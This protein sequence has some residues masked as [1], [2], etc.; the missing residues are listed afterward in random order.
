MRIGAAAAL[1]LI[2]LS[3]CGR[4]GPEPKPTAT[5]STEE[6]I[7]RATLTLLASDD[8]TVCVEP[9]TFGSPLSMWRIATQGKLQ[10]SYDLAWSPP[11]PFRPPT[12]P[13][14]RDL[15]SSVQAGKHANLAEPQMR[16]DLLPVSMQASLQ[17]QA[18]ALAPPDVATHRVTISPSWVPAGVVL[19]WW[20]EGSKQSGCDAQYVL[21]GIKW[22]GHVAFIGVRVEHW[23][24]VFALAPH[25]D[26][27]RPIAQ[28]G[29][30]LY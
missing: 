7:V 12:Q 17:G 13:T 4:R 15:R 18:S 21:S 28:W 9:E 1:L 5:L 14:L 27:W 3:A 19:R 16:H 11:K 26:D 30:W 6:K 22:N 2:C 23:G 29:T 20:P 24:T 8:K 25:G 10:E